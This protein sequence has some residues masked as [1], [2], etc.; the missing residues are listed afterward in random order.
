MK[1]RTWMIAGGACALLGACNSNDSQKSPAPSSGATNYGGSNS[2]APQGR[3]GGA[4]MPRANA[5]RDGG[6]SPGAGISNGL[7]GS[8]QT[9]SG[10]STGLN[11]GTNAPATGTTSPTNTGANGSGTDNASGSS[12]P[13]Q[14]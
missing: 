9:T 14:H 7:N 5:V 11:A 13:T 10:T 3:S 6:V 4:V 12:N 2:S 1:L 8:S